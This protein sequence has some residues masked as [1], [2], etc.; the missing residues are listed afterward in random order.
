MPS[1]VI[2]VPVLVALIAITASLVQLHFS[3][4]EESLLG[5][6]QFQHVQMDLQDGHGALRRFADGLEFK[7]VSS[8]QQAN[9][10]EDEE[11]FEML[12]EHLQKSYPAVHESLDLE[13]VTYPRHS[14]IR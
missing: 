10:V 3:K 9:H 12:H 6:P 14:S 8:F 2:T 11:Q 7:T 1:P 4:S 13:K 5:D